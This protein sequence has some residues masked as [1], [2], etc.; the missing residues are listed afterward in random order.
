MIGEMSAARSE[1][2]KQNILNTVL[3][4]SARRKY[5]GEEEV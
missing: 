2:G 1:G 3:R 4:V 5:D